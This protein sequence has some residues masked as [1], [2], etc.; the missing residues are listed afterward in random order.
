MNK[1]SLCFLV[2]CLLTVSPCNS[3][4]GHYYDGAID[5]RIPDRIRPYYPDI[6]KPPR[7]GPVCMI[8]CEYGNKVDNNGCPI[9]ACKSKPDFYTFWKRM[10]T[11]Y[12]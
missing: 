12:P 10:R 9:C 3:F 7:C 8:Y 4:A 6:I 2:F 5:T 11:A 1:I